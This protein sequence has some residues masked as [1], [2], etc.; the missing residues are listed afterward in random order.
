ML[1]PLGLYEEIVPGDLKT[2]DFE[3]VRDSGPWGRVTMPRPNAQFARHCEW[4]LIINCPGQYQ[5]VYMQETQPGHYESQNTDETSTINVT[6]PSNLTEM[7]TSATSDKGN[8]VSGL[9]D[10]Q[11]RRWKWVQDGIINGG[12]PVVEGDSRYIGSLIT[13]DKILLVEGL[14][15]DM[16]DNPGIGF[17]NHT[18]PMGLGHGGNWSE[19]ITW[20]EPVTRC[21]DT[22][23]SIELRLED[24]VESFTDN[25][26]FYVVDRGAFRGLDL[27]TL[28]SPPWIDNQTLDLF[29][30]AHKAAQM[31]N[32]LVASSLNVSLPIDE[33]AGGIVPK[34]MVKDT[35]SA[36][37]Y[38]FSQSHFDEILMDNLRGVGGPNPLI[39]DLSANSSSTNSSS[40]NSSVPNLSTPPYVNRYPD[41]FKKLLALNYS[42]ISMSKPHSHKYGIRH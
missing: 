20:I 37:P 28:E 26:T 8:T 2:V 31:H 7:F 16:R 6:I 29:G 18:I 35:G 1:T 23:L 39:P 33:T 36:S 32:V 21:A 42:A 40:A 19:D 13:Q 25:S 38:M 12:Q 27:T 14:I 4:G 30:R 15:V 17:R 41:G 9:F 22:N 11:Y 34:I 10:I 3:Y 24:S 5:G